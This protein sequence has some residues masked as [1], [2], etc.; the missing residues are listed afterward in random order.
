[1]STDRASLARRDTFNQPI[2]QPLMIPFTMVVL[3]E[4]CDGPPEMAF[5]ERVGGELPVVRQRRLNEPMTT[6]VVPAQIRYCRQAS[7]GDKDTPSVQSV[8][9]SRSSGAWLEPRSRTDHAAI[10][11]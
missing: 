6:V 4:F 5:T 2:A 11:V 9:I 3:Y 7:V 1:M 10:G 8:V